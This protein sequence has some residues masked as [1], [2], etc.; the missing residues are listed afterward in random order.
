[1]QTWQKLK[2]LLSKF[3]IMKKA[4]FLLLAPFILT[5]EAQYHKQI[6]EYLLAESAIKNFNGNVLVAKG[7]QVIYQQAFGYSN[8]D[9]KE[10]LKNNSMFEIASITKPFVSLAIFQLKEQGKLRLSDTL[11]KFIPELPYYNVTLYQMLTHTSGL[12][13]Y[14]EVFD[15]KWD[16]SKIANNKDVI[17]FVI[18]QKL[19]LSFKPGEKCEYSN[20]GYEL[21]AV[22]VERVS[23]QS[24]P[25]YLQKHICKPLGMHNTRVY[26]RRALPEMIPNYAYGYVSDSVGRYFLPDSLPQLSW[27]SR[28]DGIYGSGSISSTTGDLYLFDRALKNYT[29]LNKAA[30][31]EML[32]PRV[33]WDTAASVY[34]NFASV[35]TGS[36]EFGDYL[37]AGPSAWPGYAGDVIRYVKGDVVIIVLSNNES[38]VANISGA[39]AYIL[40]DKL[41]VKPYRHKE[42]KIDT[43]ILQLYKGVYNIPNVPKPVS[44]NIFSRDGKLFFTMI[45]D[46]TELKPESSTKFFAANGKDIQIEFIP[47]KGK[48]VR[49][50]FIANSIKKEMNKQ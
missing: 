49:S 22:V 43:T 17:A 21:L 30:Q 28:S 20:L 40:N 6:D 13:D 11:R 27:V 5:V 26:T 29:L 12:P 9:T 19:A 1:M 39:I 45:K 35:K 8:Y 16:K 34:W 10:P 14:L 32:K 4:L 33:L 23:G 2:G 47:G 50:Y 38:Q 46:T 18:K 44:V 37:H 31:Q 24:F 15:T 25:E 36:N 7:E 48:A 3:M 42:T 41:I